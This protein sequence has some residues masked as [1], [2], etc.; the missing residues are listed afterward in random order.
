MESRFED[1]GQES[2]FRSRQLHTRDFL[3]GMKSVDSGINSSF[4]LENGPIHLKHNAPLEALKR[5]RAVRSR[6]NDLFNNWE[7]NCRQ[8]NLP[9]SL[10]TYKHNTRSNQN[11]ASESPGLLNQSS[12]VQPYGVA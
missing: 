4:E 12:A 9:C 7:F 10:Q 5:R 11:T 1:A 6:K 2:M 8:L 3:K